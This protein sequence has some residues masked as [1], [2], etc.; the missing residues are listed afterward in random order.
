[1]GLGVTCVRSSSSPGV[2][3]E[4]FGHFRSF[5]EG[6]FST[7]HN[8]PDFGVAGT[9]PNTGESFVLSARGLRLLFFGVGFFAVLNTTADH[10][11]GS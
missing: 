2:T 11:I 3:G 8:L 9:S 5:E 7:Q 10:G 6:D 1:M 4:D